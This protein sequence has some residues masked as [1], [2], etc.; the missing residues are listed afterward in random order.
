MGQK[1]AITNAKSKS[2]K[3]FLGGEIKQKEIKLGPHRGPLKGP[4]PGGKKLEG[5]KKADFKGKI[6]DQKMFS[7][8]R[9]K[10]E[11]DQIGTP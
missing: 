10:A 11:R 5:S 9:N 2:K 6:E 1:T 3:I 7:R 4:P 8:G